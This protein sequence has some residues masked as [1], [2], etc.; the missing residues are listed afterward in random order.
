MKIAESYRINIFT[1]VILIIQCSKLVCLSL[2]VTF[3][4]A[5]LNLT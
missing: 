4:I 3:T 5:Y 2:S 1:A